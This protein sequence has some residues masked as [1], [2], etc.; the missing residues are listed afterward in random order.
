[1]IQFAHLQVK[2]TSMSKRKSHETYTLQHGNVIQPCNIKGIR[3]PTYEKSG[4]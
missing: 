4:H 3:V 2:S 1:M